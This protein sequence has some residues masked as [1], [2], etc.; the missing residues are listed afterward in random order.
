MKW[1]SEESDLN[2][3]TRSWTC[4]APYTMWYIIIALSLIFTLPAAL[5][6]VIDS[7]LK[8]RQRIP[9]SPHDVYIINLTFMDVI[10]ST[11]LSSDL[12][13]GGNYKSTDFWTFHF[14]NSLCLTGR[15]LLLTC[16]S[17]DTYLA[18]VHPVTYRARKSLTSSL[19]TVT[20]VWIST[21]AFGAYFMVCQVALYDDVPAL[22]L[23]VTLVIIT[24]CDFSIFWTLK[25][26][27]PG[28]KNITPQK[29]KA[30]TIIVN[31][32]IITFLAYFPLLI[33]WLLNNIMNMN[34]KDFSCTVLLPTM[35]FT[36]AGNTVS[37]IL[38]VSNLCAL[39]W[40]KAKVCS[41]PLI[42][43]M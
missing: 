29:K 27:G 2:N 22:F 24:L 42:F 34:Q 8:R 13:A 35:C 30:L 18:V 14:F 32:C 16:I 39:D 9:F 33:N 43:T 28:G 7:V 20:A 17:V 37:V 38:K 21:I 19:L 6:I 3:G 23:A 10:Y 4:D 36:V 1:I 41:C 25:K 26:P 31:K 11:I 5:V 15:P 40:L 12:Y